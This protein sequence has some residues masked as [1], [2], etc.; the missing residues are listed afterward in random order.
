METAL[1]LRKVYFRDK[2]YGYAT[3]NVRVEFK[4]GKILEQRYDAKAL[5]KTFFSGYNM[6]PSCYDCSFRCVDRVSDFTIGDFHQIGQ[7]SREMDDDKGTT[8]VWVH[9]QKGKDV[10]AQIQ[11]KMTYIMIDEKCS[12]TLDSVSKKTKY[13][14]NRDAFW[15]DAN[16]LDYRRFTKKWA[17]KDFAS[18]AANVLKPIIKRT[19]FRRQIFRL[20]KIRKYLKFN[21]RVKKANE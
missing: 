14:Y 13:P 6:R 16:N 15:D 19:P 8:C 1:S 3:A 21:E 9:T 11:K 17:K 5:M 10:F 12:S 4:H 18:T 20:I 2:S 7:F